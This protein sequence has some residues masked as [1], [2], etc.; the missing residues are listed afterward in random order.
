MHQC[1]KGRSNSN[2]GLEFLP[3]MRLGGTD[4]WHSCGRT[5][6]GYLRDRR[7][8]AK[9]KKRFGGAGARKK[10]EERAPSDLRG[11]IENEFLNITY[12]AS[13]RADRSHGRG[14]EGTRKKYN[15]QTRRKRMLASRGGRP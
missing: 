2:C 5:P 9:E 3:T 13:G 4:L 8:T 10:G 1:S 15:R 14:T 7:I 11:V 6:G 12:L